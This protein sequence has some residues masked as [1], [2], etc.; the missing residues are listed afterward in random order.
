MKRIIKSEDTKSIKESDIVRIAE[1]E[2]DGWAHGIWEYRKCDD[3]WHIHS[4]QDIYGALPRET[5]THTVKK[6]QEWLWNPEVCCQ[7]C[8]WNT[9]EMYGEAYIESVQDRYKKYTSFIT[10]FRDETGDIQGFLDGYISD[11]D[12]IYE[13]E[14]SGY[15]DSIGKS[16]VRTLTEQALWE[17]LPTRILTN[18]AM[19][20]SEKYKSLFITYDLM[21]NFYTDLYERQWNILWIY[22]ASIWSNTHAIYHAL[23]WRWIGIGWNPKYTNKIKW[24]NSNYNSDI[25]IRKDIARACR[26]WLQESLKLFLRHHNVTIREIIE[27]GQN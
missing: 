12:T 16:K 10:T 11:F 15:Y 9:T 4:K 23:W 25:G 24:T 13:N 1:I 6:I 21:K 26:D 2:Q 5:Y 19:C 14:F 17:E 20:I 8:T 27:M 3:C 22:E 7:I 18:S